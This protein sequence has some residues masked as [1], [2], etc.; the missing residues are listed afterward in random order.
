M[1]RAKVEVMLPKR[2]PGRPKKLFDLAKLAKITVAAPDSLAQ[3]LEQLLIFDSRMLDAETARELVKIIPQ[4]LI[5]RRAWKAHFV[6]YGCIACKRKRVEYQSGGLCA[7]CQGRL[8]HR[9]RECFRN[10]G[11]GRDLNEEVTA[12]TRR[13]AAAQM[14]FNGDE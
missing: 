7:R 12:L 10:V 9:I 2:P 8:S 6:E 4:L 5:M 14:L 1:K 3:A 13:F 11:A